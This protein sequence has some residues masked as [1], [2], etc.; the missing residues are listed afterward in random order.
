MHGSKLKSVLEGLGFSNVQPVI[1]S[2]NVVFESGSKNIAKLEETTQTAWPEKLGFNSTTIIRSQE[3]LQALAAKNPYKDGQHG[4]QTYQLVTFFKHPPDATL[5][6][7]PNFYDDMHVNALCS[8]IDTTASR[9]PDFMIK[10][11]KQYGKDL[12]SR[13]WLTIQRILK[14]MED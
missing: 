14:K 11:E 6:S 9:T 10:L 8:L 1:S 5:T 12:T 4:R 3:Q 7:K 13:T 2:G